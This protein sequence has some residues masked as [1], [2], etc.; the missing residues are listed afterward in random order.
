M[1]SEFIRAECM[2]K[3]TAILT[4]GRRHEKK[5]LTAK[6]IIACAKE[7]EKYVTK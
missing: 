1:S 4:T 6:E 3:A 2:R 5:P 7:L